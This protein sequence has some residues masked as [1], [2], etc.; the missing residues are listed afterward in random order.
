MAVREAGLR[1]AGTAGA[2]ALAARGDRYR[3]LGLAGDDRLSSLWNGT[4]LSGGAGRD[5]L[6]TAVTTASAYPPQKDARARQSGGDGGDR[7]LATLDLEDTGAIL[8]QDGGA[9]GDRIRADVRLSLVLMPEVE[10]DMGVTQVFDPRENI[11][12]GTRLLRWLANRFDGDLVL[13]IAGYHAGAGSLKKYG[14][15]VPPYKNT[16]KYLKMVLDRYYE[17]K[18]KE[19]AA[20]AR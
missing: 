2:D 5:T 14:N 1:I 15:T 20:E 12:G 3:V 9:G 11:L 13:T 18:E 19:A 8:V 4:F 16:R 6:A 10:A 17:Y 7:L